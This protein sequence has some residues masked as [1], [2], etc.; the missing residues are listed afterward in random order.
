MRFA[1]VRLARGPCR[2]VWSYHHLLLDGWSVGACWTRRP[3]STRRGRAGRRRRRSG[4]RRPSGTTSP[5]CGSR[6][7]RR[8]RGLLAAARWPA[9]PRRRPAASTA[10]GRARAAE[11]PAGSCGPPASRRRG[12]TPQGLARQHRLTVSTVVQGAWALLLARYSGEEDVVF[13]A[14]VSGR[15]PPLP[16]SRRCSGCFINTL[17]VRVRVPAGERVRCWLQGLQ[18]EQVEL[19]RYEHSPLVEVQGWSEVPRGTPLFESIVVFEG[20]T[21]ASREEAFQ[22]TDYP[23]TLVVGP[24]ASCSC[25]STSSSPLRRRWSTASSAISERAGGLPGGAR[26]VWR[27]SLLTAAERS[28]CRVVGDRGPLRGAS[29]CCTRSS[30]R[31]RRAAGRGRRQLRGG[32]R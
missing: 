26:R 16:G 9:S 6:T 13:G 30:R 28:S 11:R 12:P 32:G 23:L 10:A 5:G 27:R 22:R 20:F 2:I 8:R 17:P 21:P 4:A 1:L 15:P 24:A 29:C 31:R 7:S 19:R 14:T 25:G 18:A 3:P